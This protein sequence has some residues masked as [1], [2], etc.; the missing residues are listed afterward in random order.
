METKS[1]QS[2]KVDAYMTTFE[3]PLKEVMREL[4][5]IILSTSDDIG[6]EVKWSAPTFYYTG[7]LPPSDPK[8]FKRYL[9]VSNVHAKDSIMLVLPSGARVDD[10]SG[11]LE[12][13]YADGRRLLKFHSLDEV[14]VKKVQLQAIIREWLRTL[15]K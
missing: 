13:T 12:G 5:K 7:E 3:H 6:E 11:F 15:E 8:L 10:G 1:T 2:D 4:R 14:A 9:I